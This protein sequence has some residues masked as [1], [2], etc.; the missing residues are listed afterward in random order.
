MIENREGTLFEIRRYC[1]QAA[2][3]EKKDTH[4]IKP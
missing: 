3:R 2:E 1:E 4:F